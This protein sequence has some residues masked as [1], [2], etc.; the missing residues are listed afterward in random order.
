MH[1]FEF[2]DD[3]TIRKTYLI[4]AGVI[5]ESDNNSGYRSFSNLETW[6]QDKDLDDETRVYNDSIDDGIEATTNY[7]LELIAKYLAPIIH[8]QNEI[9][10]NLL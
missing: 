2:M 6:F 3:S 7:T 4:Y 8:S 5:S 9:N 1:T 10:E